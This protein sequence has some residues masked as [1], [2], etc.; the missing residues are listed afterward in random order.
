MDGWEEKEHMTQVD[1]NGLSEA[2]KGEGV[3]AEVGTSMR[4]SRE[5]LQLCELREMPSLC[6]KLGFARTGGCR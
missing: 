3:S 2:K 4:L 6:M 5:S 1:D